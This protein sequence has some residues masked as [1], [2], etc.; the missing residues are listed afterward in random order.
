MSVV[1]R[2]EKDQQHKKMSKLVGKLCTSALCR[3][4]TAGLL[5]VW[6]IIISRNGLSWKTPPRTILSLIHDCQEAQ[7]AITLPA[8]LT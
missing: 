7:E 3:T 2:F 4:L 1:H 6:A 5:F 8:L